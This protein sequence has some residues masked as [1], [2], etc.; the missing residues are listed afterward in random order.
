MFRDDMDGQAV[1][2]LGHL[3]DLCWGL[4]D[5]VNLPAS[6]RQVSQQAPLKLPPL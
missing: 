3:S 4:G 2:H 1:R 6:S 5:A